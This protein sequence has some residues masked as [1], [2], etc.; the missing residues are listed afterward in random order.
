[1]KFSWALD[2]ETASWFY[3]GFRLLRARVFEFDLPLLLASFGLL[4]TDF[5]LP[6]ELIE[7]GPLDLLIDIAPIDS[8]DLTS[9]NPYVLIICSIFAADPP[10]DFF[11]LGLIAVVGALVLLSL[12]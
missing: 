2:G 10:N 4:I 5:G 7:A 6:L 11:S 1:M 3:L 9:E 12:I 8:R